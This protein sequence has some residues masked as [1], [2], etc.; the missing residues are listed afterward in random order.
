MTIRRKDRERDRAFALAVVDTCEWAVL[1]MIDPQQKP[2][3]VPVS[4]VRDGDCVYFHTALRG[5]K[6]DCLRQCP[7][8][9]VSCVGYTRRFKHEF[10]TAYDAAM[11]GGTAEEVTEEAEKIRVLRLL[12]ER[13]TPAHMEAFDGEIAHSLARTGL[14]KIHI[15]TITGK[16]KP[17]TEADV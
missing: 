9:W 1:S 11:I 2:Y 7:R 3:G 5:R 14:W 13:H 8:V 15:D 10:T 17:D 12:C 4:I 6:I 16:Q